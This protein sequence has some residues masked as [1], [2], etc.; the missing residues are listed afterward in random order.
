M[1]N[2]LALVISYLQNG[3]EPQRR[4]AHHQRLTVLIYHVD[5]KWVVRPGTLAG[6][7]PD[8]SS[9]SNMRSSWWLRTRYLF[10][11]RTL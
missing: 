8:S 11:F 10:L 5:V 3:D 7:L 9:E 1:T 6:L 4:L 2:V